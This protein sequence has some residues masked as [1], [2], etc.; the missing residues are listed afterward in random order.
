MA[1]L[2]SAEKVVDGWNQHVLVAG[3]PVVLH[4]TSALSLDEAQVAADQYEARWVNEQI[5]AKHVEEIDNAVFG[6]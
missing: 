2:L 6:L 4:F 1:I 5:D 3:Q